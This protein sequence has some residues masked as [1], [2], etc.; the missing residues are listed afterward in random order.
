MAVDANKVSLDKLINIGE[1]RKS[2]NQLRY[3]NRSVIYW[4]IM[5]VEEGLLYN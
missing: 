3:K 4:H 1:V 5:I 2:K